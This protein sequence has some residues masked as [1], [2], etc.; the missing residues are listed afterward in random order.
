MHSSSVLLV[1]AA[2]PF[3]SARTV[4]SVLVF[5]RDGDRKWETYSLVVMG[6][7]ANNLR[8]GQALRGLQYDQARSQPGL[9][10]WRFLQAAVL[11][12]WRRRPNCRHLAR[13][14]ELFTILRQRAR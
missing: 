6:S 13:N 4:H 9:R 8:Y 7:S 11:G 12:R 14:C 5:T 1:F 3:A 10:L 2:A